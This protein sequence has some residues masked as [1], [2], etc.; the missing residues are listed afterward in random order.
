MRYVLSLALAVVYV[1]SSPAFPGHE[2]V[3]QQRQLL[4]KKLVLTL[5]DG[6][7]E[8]QIK[9][10]ETLRIQGPKAVHMIPVLLDVF[11]KTESS[12]GR[13]QLARTFAAIGPEAKAAL[14]LLL[15]EF[16]KSSGNRGQNYAEAI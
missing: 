15:D 1:S 3:T 12:V 11:Q 7:P 9:A 5:Q 10:A 13:Q 16:R 8:E 2:Y 6:T 4:Q 14:P